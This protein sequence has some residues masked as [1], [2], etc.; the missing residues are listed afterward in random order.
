[1][2]GLLAQLA[3][4]DQL[5]QVKESVAMAYSNNRTAKT[6]E[7]THVEAEKLIEHLIK[8]REEKCRPMRAKVIHLMCLMGY[9]NEKGNADYDRI[10]AFIKN[11]GSRNPRKKNLYWMNVQTLYAV[12]NQVQAMYNKSLKE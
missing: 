8:Q 9:V 6:S 11:I 1:M 12:L 3:P 2:H 4:A 5:A 10:N 7:L